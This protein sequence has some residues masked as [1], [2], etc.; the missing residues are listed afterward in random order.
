MSPNLN[1][2]MIPPSPHHFL[3]VTMLSSPLNFDLHGHVLYS[4]QSTTP[5]YGQPS[6]THRIW[7]PPQSRDSGLLLVN[8]TFI[9]TF[10]MGPPILYAKVH[11]LSLIT[12]RNAAHTLTRA[13]RHSPYPFMLE[14]HLLPACVF[15]PKR[16]SH[17][18]RD[19]HTP[20]GSAYSDGRMTLSHINN[21]W[22]RPGRASQLRTGDTRMETAQP[23][24]S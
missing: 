14:D 13:L 2:V 17:R 18:V 20:I 7:V 9:H 1:S 12:F 16:F 11:L 10:S 19:N 21:P 3:L 8:R 24:H 15:L 22:A 5:A 6:S 23:P 4:D